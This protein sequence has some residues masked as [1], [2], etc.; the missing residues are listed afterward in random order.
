ML[1]VKFSA[2]VWPGKKVSFELFAA[3]IT[4]FIWYKMYAI[5]Y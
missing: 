5:L 4:S 2:D 3:T 1:S